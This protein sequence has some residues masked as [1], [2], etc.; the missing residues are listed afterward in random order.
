[1]D[2]KRFITY[3]LQFPVE[4][5][6]EVISELK[7][8]RPQGKHLR[9]LKVSAL[10]DVDTSLDLLG[11]LSGQPPKLIDMLESPDLFGALEVLGD[12]LDQTLPGSKKRSGS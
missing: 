10:D 11:S 1:M 3:K 12:F 6:D 9:N 7:I 5:G 8:R 2:D 4:Y